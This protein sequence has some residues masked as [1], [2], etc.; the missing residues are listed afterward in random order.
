MRLVPF[1]PILIVVFHFSGASADELNAAEKALY[2]Q[3]AAQEFKSVC[4]DTDA[5]ADRVKEIA[6]AR[7]WHPRPVDITDALS[8]PDFAWDAQ[9][10]LIPVGQAQVRDEYDFVLGVSNSDQYVECYIIVSPIGYQVVRSAMSNQGMKLI[11][12]ND[13]SQDSTLYKVA[14]YSSG[15]LKNLLQDNT[16]IDLTYREFKSRPGLNGA[17]IRYCHGSDEAYRGCYR[18]LNLGVADGPT[19]PKMVLEPWFGQKAVSEP[20]GPV[21]D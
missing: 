5:N 8:P 3:L 13:W 2:A 6:Q 15:E 10:S 16:G 9:T 1:I 21:D 20:P 14:H 19:P 11:E 4:V 12:E 17:R 7:G 18:Y